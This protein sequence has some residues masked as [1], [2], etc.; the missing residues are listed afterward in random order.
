MTVSLCFSQMLAFKRVDLEA[1]CGS[2]SVYTAAP[3]HH[4]KSITASTMRF[5]DR[6]LNRHAQPMEH[7]LAYSNISDHNTVQEALQLELN[8]YLHEPQMDPFRRIQGPGPEIHVIYCDPLRYWMACIF[9]YLN[10]HF[11]P[12]CVEC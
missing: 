10:V 7:S 3:T 8:S 12:V 6:N 2:P 9:S 4:L 1:E 11:S 5:L